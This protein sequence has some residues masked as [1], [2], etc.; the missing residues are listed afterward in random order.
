MSD[1]IRLL[2]DAMRNILGELTVRTMQEGS[3]QHPG[4]SVPASSIFSSVTSHTTWSGMVSRRRGLKGKGTRRKDN[5]PP[6]VLSGYLSPNLIFICRGEFGL[7]HF[8]YRLL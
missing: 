5:T 6:S 1:D 8:I 2:R 3:K 4:Q 7:A